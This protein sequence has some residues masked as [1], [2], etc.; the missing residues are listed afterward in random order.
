MLACPVL[1]PR[2]DLGVS[3]ARHQDIAFHI[4]NSVG[5]HV[6]LFRGSIT[7]PTGSLC[8]LH[9]MGYP[10]VVQHSVPAAGTLSRAGFVTRWV[11][12]NGFK[13]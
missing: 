3:A 2:W 6:L 11:P 8:T 5:S 4:W 13:S 12:M 9:N 7:Q 10:I 1:R